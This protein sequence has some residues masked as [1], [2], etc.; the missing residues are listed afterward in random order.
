MVFVT[1]GTQNF[2]FNRLLQAVEKAV[3]NNV[4]T[5][6]VIAQIGN[7]EFQSKHIKCISFLDKDAFVEHMKEARFIISHAGTG[8]I[9]S[10]LKMGKKIIVGPRLSEYGEHI[11]DHQL[12]ILEAFSKMNL[13]VPL[14]KD[15][16]DLEEKI[17]KLH[18][19]K[20]NTFRSNTKN[21]NL[22][23]THLINDL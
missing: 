12:E 13:I 11:D 14:N 3:K 2:N 22:Q 8:S 10:A 17:G 4:I 19:Y 16:D 7:N 21:F 15:L 1:L 20:L 23:L 5:D 9:V 6:E 18:Q